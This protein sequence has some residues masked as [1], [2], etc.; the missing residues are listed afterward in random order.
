MT[1]PPTKT[2]VVTGASGGIGRAV[3]AGARRLRRRRELCGQRR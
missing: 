2:A 3:A 1:N